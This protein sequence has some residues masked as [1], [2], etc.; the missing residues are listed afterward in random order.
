MKKYLCNP[1]DV[2]KYV[3]YGLIDPRDSRIFYIGKSC[4]GLKQVLRHNQ[5]HSL[6]RKGEAK[7]RRILEIMQ[8]GFQ[9]PLFIILAKCKSHA[10]V[11]RKERALIRKFSKT[12]AL[13]NKAHNRR[14]DGNK[15]KNSIS[16]I[17]YTTQTADN[18]TIS[19]CRDS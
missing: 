11:V 19:E 17:R 12:H 9:S 6:R 13:T 3:V 15:K 1:A 5:P 18:A 14:K 8:S 16:H 10:G 2:D 4:S 7:N